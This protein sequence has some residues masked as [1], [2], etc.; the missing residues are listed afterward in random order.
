VTCRRSSGL[1]WLVD[2]THLGESGSRLLSE[3][4]ALEDRFGLSPMARRRLQWELLAPVIGT[5]ES[6]SSDARFLRAV[7]GGDS[8]SL[9]GPVR[10]GGDRCA[11]VASTSCDQVDV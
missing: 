9:A 6:D 3:I 11:G 10:E 4:W 2:R 5:S 8:G 1:A 7:Q